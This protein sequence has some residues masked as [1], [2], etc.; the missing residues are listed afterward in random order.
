MRRLLTIAIL[1]CA[2]PASAH[3]SSDGQLWLTYTGDFKIDGNDSITATAIARSRS[4]ELSLGQSLLRA[5]ISHRL[6]DGKSL[7]L[8]Y[9]YVR[10]FNEGT[11]DTIQH[12]LG[13]TLTIPLTRHLDSRIQAEEVN[14]PGKAELGLRLRGRMKWVHSLDHEQKVDLQLSDELIWSVNDTKWGQQSGWT[15]NRASAAVHFDLND[16]LGIAPGYT[17]QLIHRYSNPDRNDHILGL[18][19]D[20]HF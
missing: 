16:H 2:L 3:A 1:L 8:T 10:N 9:T 18:T 7:S 20:S 6:R 12:R 17:W 13:Q 19:L 15:A 5:G 14:V 4:D 11:A